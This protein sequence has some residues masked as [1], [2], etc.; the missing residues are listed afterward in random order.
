MKFLPIHFLIVLS[1][2]LLVGCAQAMDPAYPTSTYPTP[3]TAEP[4]P[5]TGT[6]LPTATDAP[7][8][9]LTPTPFKPFEATVTID[10]LFLRSGPGFLHSVIGMYNTGDKVEVLGRVPGW[11]WVYIGTEDDFHGYMKVELLE[12]SASFYDAPEVIPDGFRIVKGHVYTPSGNPASHITLTLTPP[13]GEPADEDS[14]TTDVQGQFYF[15][16]PEGSRGTWTL[17][18]GAYGCESSAVDSACSLVGVFPP[19]REVDVMESA[20]IWINLEMLGQ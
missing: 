16:L 19:A 12:L 8:P 5:P 13:D 18:A 14:A 17:A 9:T 2:V 6:P 3:I 1:V 20:E 7:V 11:S 10:G 4:N 15:F